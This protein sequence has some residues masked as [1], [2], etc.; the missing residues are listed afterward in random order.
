MPRPVEVKPLKNYRI[1]IKY[2][3]G[4]EGVIDLSDLAGKGVFTVWQ[5]YREFQKVHI[6]PSGEIAWSEEID[7]CPDAIY[8]KI[9]GK[10]PEELFPKLRELATQHA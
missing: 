8:M 1:W 9:T 4:V 10:R 5:D 2:S 6:G 3:D 7:L